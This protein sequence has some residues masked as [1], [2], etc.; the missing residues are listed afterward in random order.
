MKAS[1]QIAPEDLYFGQLP[2]STQSRCLPPPHF[3]F[4]SSVDWAKAWDKVNPM[5]AVNRNK[6]I[7]LRT[8]FSP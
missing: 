5:N 2:R 7:A 6:L 8:M 1:G 4:C 3:F